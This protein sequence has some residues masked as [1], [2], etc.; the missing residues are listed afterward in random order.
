MSQHGYESG[1]L[2]LPFVGICTFAKSPLCLDWDAIDADVAVMGAPFDFGTQWRSGARFGPRGIREASTLFS[3]GHGGAYDHEDDVTYLPADKVS[4]QDIGDADIV[5]T[6]T[7]KS[8]AN[9]EFG[10]R[11]M[12]AAG[13]LPDVISSD[14]HA[15]SI[16]GPAFDLLT[17][18]SKFL[19]LGLDLAT[20]I[21]LATANA[22]AAIKRPD[23]GTLKVGSVGEATVIDQAT[24]TF[25]YA[26]SIG[27]R[28]T[29]D[30]RLL[31]A[32][33]VLAGRWWHPG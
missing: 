2:N 10:V 18:M 30:R 8:H 23:L 14:V 17:T 7:V 32:G 20:V 13:F 12:L 29:G 19:C 25:D 1:R 4:I 9:I 3:F 15:I 6:D 16:E 24:G 26:D 33:V 31:S 21:K 27:E 22:A 5:H 28:L 11:K